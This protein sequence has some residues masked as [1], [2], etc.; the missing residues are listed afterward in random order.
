[1]NWKKFAPALSV[2]TFLVLSMSSCDVIDDPIKDGAPPPTGGSDTV[3]RNVLVEDFTGHR[4]KNCPKASKVIEDLVAFYGDRVIPLAIHS[5]PSEFTAPNTDY[6]T[7]FRT[8]DGDAIAQFFGGVPAQ[9]IGMVSRIG[10]TG[11]GISHFKLHTS[12]PTETNNIIDEVAIAGIEATSSVSCTTLN[13]SVTTTFYGSQ[14]G[15]YKLVVY[16]KE[17]HII[18]PQL[19][20]DDTRDPDYDHKNVLRMSI[21]NDPM[22]EILISGAIADSTVVTET[23]TNTLDPSWNTSNLQIVALI[24]DDSNKEVMQVIQEDVQ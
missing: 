3:Y 2:I 15:D 20:P 10:Y 5:G 1:M 17:N 6:P 12:W 19:M 13:T 16:L 14:N 4:C 23:F 9:P 21:S 8:A 22:G 18:A 7:D 11:S 24:Y